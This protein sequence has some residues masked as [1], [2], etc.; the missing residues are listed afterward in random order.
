MDR[1]E[2]DSLR[3][4]ITGRHCVYC[5]ELSTSDEHF[6]PVCNGVGGYILPACLEC[7][8][9]AG[10]EYPRDFKKRTEHVKDQLSKRYPA[11]TLDEILASKEIQVVDTLKAEQTRRRRLDW[12]AEIY[13]QTIA[14]KHFVEII[15]GSEFKYRAGCCEACGDPVPIR[16]GRFCS[17][18]CRASLR[19]GVRYIR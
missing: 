4:R 15:Q 17:A 3:T 8:K 10:T 9:L 16:G 13:L 19:R 1:R 14:E 12:D 11:A 6:P 5:G 2:H 18:F 7:N